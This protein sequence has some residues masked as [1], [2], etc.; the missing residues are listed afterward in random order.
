[1]TWGVLDLRIQ[2]CDWL[3]VELVESGWDLK[4]I[5]K[6]IVNLSTYQQ[7]S[8]MTAELAAIDPYN[9]KYARQASSAGC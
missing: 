2:N 1:M 4:H 3:S 5:V 7:S 9:Y 8:T 6:L